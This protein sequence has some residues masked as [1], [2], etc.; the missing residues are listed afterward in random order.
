MYRDGNKLIYQDG[1]IIA[2]RVGN[3]LQINL[4]DESNISSPVKAAC[5]HRDNIIKYDPQAQ[6]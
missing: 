6:A 2:E 1:R 3:I 4:W 5:I